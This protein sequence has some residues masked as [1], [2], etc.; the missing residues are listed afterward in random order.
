M[1]GCLTGG[2]GYISQGKDPNKSKIVGFWSGKWS[3][4]QQ[5]YPVHKQELLALVETLKCFRG[6]LHGTKFMEGVIRAKSEYINDVDELIRGRHP[7]THPIYVDMALI[8]VMN[9]EVRQSS[10]LA[11][12]PGLNYKETQD[13]K[14]RVEWEEDTPTCHHAC[15]TQWALGCF[16]DQKT[17]GKK[18]FL[19]NVKYS[20]A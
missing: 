1:D 17:P 11:E 15:L 12:K 18:I 16:P 7:K 10:Q 19:D 14:T 9:T 3:A 4:A 2:G 8:S 6:I 20:T 13:R 5:N